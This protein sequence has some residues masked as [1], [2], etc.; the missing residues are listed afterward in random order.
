MWGWE[1]GRTGEK[2][3]RH[4]HSDPP[5]PPL[6]MPLTSPFP[7]GRR[8]S[9]T[10]RSTRNTGSLRI[11]RGWSQSAGGAGNCEQRRQWD[12]RD[13]RRHRSHTHRRRPGGTHCGSCCNVTVTVVIT[14][15][16]AVVHVSVVR[17]VHAAG[18]VARLLGVSCRYTA[19]NCFS[20]CQSVG[21]VQFVPIV[22][23]FL[24]EA[25]CHRL[26]G[27]GCGQLDN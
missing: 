24:F 5:L 10:T 8:C 13:R 25:R 14:I 17:E 21:F 1:S 4:C 7:G 20:I 22:M 18:A 23:V 11:L 12:D 6:P 2:R 3:D 19:R 16:V 27:I 15:D 26:Q 9:L